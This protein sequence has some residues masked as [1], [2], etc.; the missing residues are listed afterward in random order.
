MA[1]L[2]ADSTRAVIVVPEWRTEPWWTTLEDII[3]DAWVAP[4]GVAV[5]ENE[6]GVLPAP[7]WRVWVCVVDGGLL[8]CKQTLQVSPMMLELFGEQWPD[9]PATESAGAVNGSPMGAAPED[10]TT[11]S[12]ILEALNIVAHRMG[13]IVPQ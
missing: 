13:H 5:Y 3:I 4:T 6:E 1:K 2:V 7:R 8:S 12:L 10:G 9:G 11:G